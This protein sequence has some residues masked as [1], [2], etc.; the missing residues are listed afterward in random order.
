MCCAARWDPRARVARAAV[1]LFVLGSLLVACGGEKGGE[2][3]GRITID[4]GVLP[5]ADMA[6]LFL[7]IRKGFFAEEDL[8]IEPHFVEAGAVAIP[9]VVSGEFEFGWPSSTSLL[10]A[11]SKGLPLRIVTRGTRG[12]SDPSESW[13]DVLV[14]ADGPIRSAQDLEDKTIGVP[15][16]VGLATLTTNAA[17]EKVGVDISTINYTEI[18][19]PEAIPALERGSVDAVYVTEPFSTLGLRADHRSVLNPVVATASD[20]IVGAG[21]VTSERY[22]AEHRDVVDRFAR[23]MNRSFNYAA[24]RPKEVREVVPTYTS[25]PVDVAQEMTL[26]DFSSYENMS[27]LKLNG[28]LAKRYGYLDQVPAMAKLFY[29]G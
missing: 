12:G 17:L 25:I 4:V 21:Y 27:T 22:I 20:F 3:G 16:L 23:A 8:E 1:S 26:P 2:P 5:I 10:I 15:A 19:Y 28:E 24:A 7:G 6:P 29:K 13:T 14:R 18:P 11:V 9:A